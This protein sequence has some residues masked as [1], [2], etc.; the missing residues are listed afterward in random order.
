MP[1]K[2]KLDIKTSSRKAREKLCIEEGIKLD[3][4]HGHPIDLAD[5]DVFKDMSDQELK[6]HTKESQR[7]LRFEKGWDRATTVI[8]IVIYLF[9]TL[10]IIGLL[11]FG[12]KQLF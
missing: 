9:I 12:I 4:H 1:K 3:R 5:W 6:Y 8:G 7:Q 11:V 10:G 2:K